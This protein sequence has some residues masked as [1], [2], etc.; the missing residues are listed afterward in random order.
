MKRFIISFSVLAVFL[1]VSPLHAQEATAT[2]TPNKGQQKRQEV[3][4]KL[5]EKRATR[6]ARLDARRQVIVNRI[7]AHARKMLNRADNMLV[8]MDRIWTKV[9][10]RMEKFKTAGKDFSS[11]NDLVIQV[12]TMRQA[13]ITATTSAQTALSALEGSNDPKSAVV[14]FRQNFKDV[15]DAF[16]AYKRSI[17]DVINSLKGMS[18][19]IRQSPTPAAS[20]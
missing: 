17:V 20:I 3:Q 9:E 11:L 12:G 18:G 19:V 7:L 13:A 15:K 2:P 8:R 10:S 5:G 16:K 4:T 1:F 6:A 14:A